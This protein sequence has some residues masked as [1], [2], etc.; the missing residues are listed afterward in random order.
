MSISWLLSLQIERHGFTCATEQ[1][2][3]T[4]Q[5]SNLAADT[6]AL[7]VTIISW[8]LLEHWGE[9]SVT[10]QPEQQQEAS[11]THRCRQS[12]QIS[13]TKNLGQK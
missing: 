5:Y 8:A 9:Q 1:P 10:W 3:N 7:F 13:Q 2:Q 12:D 4:L 6:F 11:L